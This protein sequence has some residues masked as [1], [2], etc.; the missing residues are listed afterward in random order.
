MLKFSSDFALCQERKKKSDI[1][2][3]ANLRLSFSFDV[4]ILHK[5]IHK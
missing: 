4:E 5:N 1:F 2:D 3:F